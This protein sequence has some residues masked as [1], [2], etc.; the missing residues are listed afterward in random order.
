MAL[1]TEE[2]NKII[3]EETLRNEIRNEEETKITILDILY[4]ILFVS[5]FSSVVYLIKIQ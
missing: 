2:R 4:T 5:I 3:E 1:T